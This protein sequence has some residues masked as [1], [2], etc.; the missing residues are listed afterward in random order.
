MGIFAGTEKREQVDIN[1]YI[2]LEEELIAVKQQYGIEETAGAAS[3]FITRF[4]DRRA[5]R[6]EHLVCR[7]KYLLLA[8]VTGFMGGH[9]FYAKQYT[10]AVLYLLF[11]WTGFPLAMTI[12]DLM[13]A[14]PKEADE[15]GMIL[16]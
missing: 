2:A 6:T 5:A 7:K 14:L 3:G 16:I 9:R 10:T 15:N 12:I 4:F 1:Q 13:A 8:A 11:F